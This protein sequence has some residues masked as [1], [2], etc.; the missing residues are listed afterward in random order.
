MLIDTH[1]HL[2]MMTDNSP[3]NIVADAESAG[4]G[5]LIYCAADPDCAPK[6]LEAVDRFDN[7]FGMLGLHPEHA[8]KNSTF[9]LSTFQ[10]QLLN[11]KIV[12]VGE[13]GLD[14][15][16]EGYDK[17]AQRALFE[18]QLELA[19]SANLPIAVHSRDAEDD[20]YDIL[21]NYDIRGTM[22]CF[23]GSYDFAKK[24]LDLGFYISASGIITFKNAEALR[25]VF[26]Q[27][28]LDRLLVETDAPYCSPVPHRGETCRPAFVVETAKCFATMY[29]KSFEEMSEI[30]TRN[31][32]N[33]YTKMR[34]HYA[35]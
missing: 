24:M 33:L 25:D 26:R 18:S 9:P 15:H 29:N 8:D 27:I 32:L 17:S 30:L 10:S 1:C 19:K 34:G 20:T 4:V 14:Y 21:K 7:V 6:I 28:P 13:I 3:D 23:G 11:P 22:H 35:S 16:Y 5:A 31:T 2:G 12:G